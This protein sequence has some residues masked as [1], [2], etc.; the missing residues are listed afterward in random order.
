M[1]VF[2]LTTLEVYQF[3]IKWDEKRKIKKYFLL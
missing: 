3:F 1:I 2:L